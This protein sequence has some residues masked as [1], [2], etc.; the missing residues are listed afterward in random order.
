MLFGLSRAVGADTCKESQIP[1]RSLAQTLEF[2]EFTISGVES[3]DPVPTGAN[4]VNVE[5]T[6]P[7]QCYR[8]RSGGEGPM[9]LHDQGHHE[10]RK[11]S[12]RAPD[13]Y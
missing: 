2:K 1:A 10:P 7:R 6:R 8:L 5:W 11:H 4:Q 9:L 12:R 13:K 3:D